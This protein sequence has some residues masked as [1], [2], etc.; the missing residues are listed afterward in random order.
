VNPAPQNHKHPK[1]PIAPI[2][3]EGLNAAECGALIGCSEAKVW[4]L[5]FD[6]I[7]PLPIRKIGRLTTFPRAAVMEWYRRR[8]TFGPDG[9]AK[10]NDQRRRHG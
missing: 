9:E 5:R 8:I 6:P 7:D 3:P 10:L 2:V 4:E 1:P